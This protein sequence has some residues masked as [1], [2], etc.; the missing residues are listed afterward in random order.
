M[1]YIVGLLHTNHNKFRFMMQA[2]LPIIT[3]VNLPFTHQRY[4]LIFCTGEF[5]G[6]NIERK[7]QKQD[8]PVLNI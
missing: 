3:E 1:K 2:R 8:M 6:S 7:K 5:H 4:T